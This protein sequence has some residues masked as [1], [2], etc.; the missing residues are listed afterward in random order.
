MSAGSGKGT[1]GVIGLGIMGGAMA[2]N[3]A[4]AGFSVVGYDVDAGACDRAKAGGVAIAGSAA[5]VAERAPDIVTSLAVTQAVYDTAGI[6]AAT[7]AGPRTVIEA[8]TL[9][10][11]DKLAV[12]KILADAGHAIVDSPMLGTGPHAENAEL[13]VYASGEDA[14]LARLEPVFGAIGRKTMKLGP[15]GNGS[16]MKLVTN[17]LVAINNVAAGETMVLGMKAGLDARQVWEVINAGATNRVF[18]FRGKMMVDNQYVPPTM[19]ISTWAK[20]MGAIGALAHGLAAPTPLFNATQAIYD[21]AM[22]NGQGGEDTAAVCSVLE[23]MAGIARA[24][25]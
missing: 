17:H 8:S 5:D 22:A 9:A 7:K 21:A 18:E 6:I 20:D 23:R 3:L 4:K 12:G 14:T 15:Y 24:A 11:D 19:K 25:K 1:I 2:R 13:V 10:L 16:K